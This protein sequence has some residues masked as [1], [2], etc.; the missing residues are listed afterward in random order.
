M[1]N[2]N[3]IKFSKREAIILLIAMFSVV[4]IVACG[5]AEDI[6]G[7]SD[8]GSIQIP[9]P[10]PDKTGPLNTDLPS[11]G[12]EYIPELPEPAPDKPTYPNDSYYTIYAP[13]VTTTGNYLDVSYLDTNSLNDIWKKHVTRAGS[14]DSLRWVIRDGD[15]RQNDPRNG[16]YYY[17]DKNLDIVHSGN[18]ANNLKVKEFVG[19]VIVKYNQD[20][21]GTTSDVW[22][23]GGLYRTLLNKYDDNPQGQQGYGRYNNN[24]FNEFMRSADNRRDGDLSII[25]M[26]VG[27]A[28]ID[29]RYKFQFSYEFGVDEY[30]STTDDN[31]RK[32][33]SYFLGKNPS[34]YY[35]SK[36][37]I[38]VNHSGNLKTYNFRFTMAELSNLWLQ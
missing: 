18:Y 32:N 4:G 35:N 33:S 23:I 24:N 27:Y 20:N 11:W 31:Y 21:T 10:D 38:K 37:N 1:I 22:T 7:S 8:S 14:N 29:D 36:L 5:N 9:E 12:S 16:N 26:N 30:Y 19:G 6:S 28:T 25:L 2:K 13:F 3:L 15:N 17:F 34:E